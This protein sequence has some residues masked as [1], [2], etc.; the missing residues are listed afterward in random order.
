VP[1]Q[2]R[3]KFILSKQSK[4][5]VVDRFPSSIDAPLPDPGV[6]CIEIDA[7]PTGELITGD[8]NN[9][10]SNFNPGMRLSAFV[11]PDELG[12]GQTAADQVIAQDL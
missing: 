4:A 7:W 9:Q 3:T 8:V 10:V 1:V 12:L 11:G 2:L 6:G 5:E